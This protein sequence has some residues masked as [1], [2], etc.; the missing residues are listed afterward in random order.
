VPGPRACA[1]DRGAP[2]RRDGNGLELYYDR[3]AAE[4]FGA[5][6]KPV[7][8]AVPLDPRSLLAG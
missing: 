6:G 1:A 4:W 7:M 2:G 8:K 5:D 3:P